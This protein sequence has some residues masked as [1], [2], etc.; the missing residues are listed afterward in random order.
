MEAVLKT[1][2][3]PTPTA[4]LPCRW[5][6]WASKVLLG[7]WGLL[8]LAALQE[9]VWSLAFL[10]GEVGHPDGTTIHDVKPDF[11]IN[12]IDCLQRTHN[13]LTQPQQVFPPLQ[14]LPFHPQ[15]V[16][17]EGRRLELG[18]HTLQSTTAQRTDGALGR[19][20][21]T[22]AA[23]GA[24]GSTRTAPRRWGRGCRFVPRRGN[25]PLSLGRDRPR[26]PLGLR[27]WRTRGWRCAVTQQSLKDILTRGGRDFR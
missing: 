9:L 11:F 22:A 15:K 4:G 18:I 2:R 19:H 14:Q 23:Y 26:R 20:A 24:L 8:R 12:G 27:Y 7:R 3:C 1:R 17:D 16:G 6:L 25:D 21:S 10:P 13:T 5:L